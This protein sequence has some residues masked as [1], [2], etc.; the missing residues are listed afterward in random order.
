MKS[1]NAER[2]IEKELLKVATL[3]QESSKHNLSTK[4]SYSDGKLKLSTEM[5]QNFK[6]KRQVVYPETVDKITKVNSKE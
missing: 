6:K 2:E 5:N 4:G 3:F 1:G